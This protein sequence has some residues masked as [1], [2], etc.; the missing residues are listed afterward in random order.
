MAETRE[1]PND[2]R[3]LCHRHLVS[4]N[5]PRAPVRTEP[6]P[7]SGETGWKPILHCFAVGKATIPTFVTNPAHCR[8]RSNVDYLARETLI[9]E[10]GLGLGVSVFHGRFPTELYAALFINSDTLYPDQI[11]DLHYIFHAFDTEIR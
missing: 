3:R 9:L 6:R 7:R 1:P 4:Q 10:R 2:D 5:E 11:S 8:V